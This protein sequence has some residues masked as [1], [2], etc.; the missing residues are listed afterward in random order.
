MLAFPLPGTFTFVFHGPGNNLSEP[1]TSGILDMHCRN[2]V[3]AYIATCNITVNTMTSTDAGFY[4]VR[5]GNSVGSS[6]ISFEVKYFGPN[7]E[8]DAKVG[9]SLST[10]AAVGVTLALVLVVVGVVVVW[11]WRRHWVLPCASFSA[12]GSNNADCNQPAVLPPVSLQHEEQQ[13]AGFNEV[14]D[15]NQQATN[16]YDSLRT[17]DVGVKSEYAELS[18]Y[19][20]AGMNHANEAGPLYANTRPSS[21]RVYQNVGESSLT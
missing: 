12:N 21:G 1:V 13:N 14:Q 19:V 20:N 4:S 9:E 5:I 3:A 7:T 8:T 11:M 15:D 16:Q 17:L 6:N 18:H 10:G 2:M